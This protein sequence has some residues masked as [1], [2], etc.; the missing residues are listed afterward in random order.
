MGCIVD[1]VLIVLVCVFPWTLVFVVPYWIYQFIMRFR[2]YRYLKKG[3]N[4][5]E[6]ELKSMR[7]KEIEEKRVAY[8]TILN[9]PF[10]SPTEK[11]AARYVIGYIEKHRNVCSTDTSIL[12]VKKMKL[13]P[14]FLKP[15]V[16]TDSVDFAEPQTLGWIEYMLI[17]VFL[18]VSLYAFI[19][20]VLD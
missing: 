10:S 11:A 2:E 19:S 15:K 16:Y 20:E 14:E 6:K 1:L 17:A 18:F 12:L 3:D 5:L 7:P 4:F 8:L 13:E 9:S